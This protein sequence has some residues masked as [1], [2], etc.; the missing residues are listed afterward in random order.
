MIKVLIMK[1]LRLTAV[2][3]SIVCGG[4]MF[5]PKVAVLYSLLA[6]KENGTQGITKI[7]KAQDPAS[8][9]ALAHG[10]LIGSQLFRRGVKTEY[11]VRIK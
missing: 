1:E 3:T 4:L 5:S 9:N 2:E 11:T 6:E 10:L 7:R 8:R